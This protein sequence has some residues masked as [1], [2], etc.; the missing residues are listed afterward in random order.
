MEK[1]SFFFWPVSATGL[2]PQIIKQ[3]PV[4]VETEHSVYS[5]SL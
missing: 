3:V 5:L 1:H 4:K 2:D